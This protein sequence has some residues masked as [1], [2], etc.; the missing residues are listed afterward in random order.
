MPKNF[1]IQNDGEIAVNVFSGFLIGFAILM[2]DESMV[3]TTKF[4]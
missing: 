4:K 1:N 3:S 2:A